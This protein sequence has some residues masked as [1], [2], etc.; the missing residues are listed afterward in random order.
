MAEIERGFYAERCAEAR[1]RGS[2]AKA[3]RR[4]VCAEPERGGGN[5]A[6]QR[7]G[8]LSGNGANG[9]SL[10]REEDLAGVS[11]AYAAGG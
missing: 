11:G 1:R 4:G 9:V 10:M 7:G 6:A 2:S 8:S 3:Q 5:A